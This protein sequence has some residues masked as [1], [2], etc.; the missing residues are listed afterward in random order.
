MAT[1]PSAAP[2]APGAQPGAGPA[3]ARVLPQQPQ[4]L[5][6][7]KLVLGTIALSLATF[8]NVLDSSI[9]NVSIPA[10][11]G[12]LGVAPNQGT[13]VIT[14]FAVANA[15]SVPLTGWL[16]TRFGAVR[17]F[18]TSILLFVLASWLC[19]VAPNLETLLAA[20]VLQGAV[21]G[22]MIPLSQSLLLSSYPPAKS[23]MALALWG[24]T[25]LVAPIMGPLLGGWISDN[26]TWPWIFYIN[27]PVGIITAYATW[28]IY[29]DR[30]TPTKVL[31]IDR[32]G[33]ALLVIWVGSMQLMLDKGKE[34][35]WF[36]STEIVVLTLVAI[37]GFLFFLAWETY[38]KHPIVDICLFKGRNFSSGVVAISVAY[39]LFFGNLVILP[40]WLQTIVGYTA[41][42]AGIVM[43]PVG[44]FAILLS[45]VIGRN[46]PKM[47]ARWVAT[48]A[49]ITFGIVSLMRSGFTTQVDTWTLMV[50]TLIQGAAMAMFFIPLTSIIL[51]GQPAEKIPAAS[52]LS[53][54]VRITFGGI[55]ASISTT[56][57]ENRSALHH[58]Q[59]VEQV[60]PYN[61][62]YH[63]QLSHLMQMGMSQ[64]Q[65]VGVIE[66]NITQQAAMLGANDIFWISG[67]LFFVLIGFVWLTRPAKGGG[68]SGDAMGAH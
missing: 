16:T 4:P 21:A 22:P 18:I 43:A 3:P 28:A 53:N 44:I 68:G 66:R 24:M 58:A 65:A 41:T 29:K 5:T 35:D 67:M 12:D 36:H 9:A 23:T 34:L 2:A 26:M 11:S 49:F 55:G 57:W 48:A 20:R 10:I 13:W 31:P 64:A 60:N 40:L 19:G 39:G 30:E 7:G 14:S 15:I 46:L 25:T 37:V 32:I 56:V 61:P 17:L 42:D 52:G 45:P 62:A 63:D 1:S 50:P 54:F 59:L 47:D 38:E 33:L 8:M 51:S 27:V 6:G